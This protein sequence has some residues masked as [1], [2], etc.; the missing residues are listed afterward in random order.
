[1]AQTANKLKTEV[2]SA[3]FPKPVQRQKKLRIV[4]LADHLGLSKGTVSRALRDYPDISDA[5]KKRVI[6][7]A[8]ALGYQPS[9]SALALSTGLAHSAALIL[10]TTGDCVQKSYLPDFLAGISMR[11]SRDNWTLTVANA[12]PGSD[13]LAVQMR[14]IGE[15][16]VDGFIVPRP[17]PVDP[18][19]EM[20]RKLNIPFVVYGR[21]VDMTDVPSFDFNGEKAMQNA[22]ERLAAMGHRR[23][24]HIGASSAFY[25]QRVRREGYLAGL[26][27]AGLAY[28]PSLYREDAMTSAEGELLAAEILKARVPPTAIVCAMDEAA[29]G[30]G[31]AIEA[32]GLTIGKDVSLIGYDGIHAA[33]IVPTPL[34]T[35]AVNSRLAGERLA[36]ILIR[37]IR[38][39]MGPGLQELR[40]A[41]LIERQSD[42]P[43]S[44][45]PMQLAEKIAR[46]KI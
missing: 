29:L 8:Q 42:R 43:P 10:S 46:A 41:S 25:L 22:V 45:Q 26:R 18:R 16:K 23:I 17:R 11:L 38:G 19:V 39:G 36:D 2:G 24:A 28:D 35:F 30:A 13:D 6:E 20:L 15:R 32:M 12:G 3:R 44:L 27:A 33:S 40:D 4:D 34:T 7:A 21:V 1:M 9:S 14:L 31:R 5:T 37:R